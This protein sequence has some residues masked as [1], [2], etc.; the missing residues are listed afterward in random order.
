MIVE[1]TFQGGYGRHGGP[2][3]RKGLNDLAEPLSRSERDFIALMVRSK[4]VRI[5]EDEGARTAQ[6]PA[7]KS[8]TK[9]AVAAPVLEPVTELAVGHD[10]IAAGA[11][12]HAIAPPP[13]K[14][15]GASKRTG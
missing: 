2:F 14:R 1:S 9:L 3:L 11:K 4:L 12:A 6:P 15:R 5:V 10:A 7:P 13:A 8:E